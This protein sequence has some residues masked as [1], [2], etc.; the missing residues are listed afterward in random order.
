MLATL[1]R[2]IELG[3]VRVLVGFGFARTECVYADHADS[4]KFDFHWAS[5]LK[6]L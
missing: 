5:Q 2:R 3:L 6:I 1:L 4:P